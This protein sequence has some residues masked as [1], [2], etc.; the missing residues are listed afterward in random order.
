MGEKIFGLVS[1]AKMRGDRQ[2]ATIDSK[3]RQMEEAKSLCEQ[4]SRRFETALADEQWDAINATGPMSSS[5]SNANA[6]DAVLAEFVAFMDRYLERPHPLLQRIHSHQSV[7]D[8]VEQA[9][10]ALDNVFADKEQPTSQNGTP[11]WQLEVDCA[12]ELQ[13]QQ[14]K[15]CLDQARLTMSDRDMIDRILQRFKQ[16]TRRKRSIRMTERDLKELEWKEAIYFKLFRLNK[17]LPIDVPEWFIAPNEVTLDMSS[18]SDLGSCGEIYSGMWRHG[19]KVSVRRL[20]E[21]NVNIKAMMN[22]TDLWSRLNHPHIMKLFGACHQGRP[23]FVCED[24][25]RGH[26]GDYLSKPEN[27]K[28]TWRMLY[29]ASLGLYYLHSHRIAH[30]DLRCRNVRIGVDGKAKLSNFSYSVKLN[31]VSTDTVISVTDSIRW[32]A[33]ECFN[34]S[35]S[36]SFASDIYSFGMCIIEATTGKPPWELS[37]DEMVV[38]HFVSSNQLPVQPSQLDDASWQLVQRMCAHEPTARPSIVSVVDE[39]KRLMQKE[40]AAA[41]LTESKK[42][43]FCT[44]CGNAMLGTA[45]FCNKCGKRVGDHPARVVSCV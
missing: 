14:L 3:C 18:S 44:S 8:A 39:L 11:L 2:V 32:K 19:T 30:G 1:F 35:T 34:A 16:E 31:E 26:L 4:V 27:Q 25:V 28:K 6:L 37:E 12:R 36:F 13:Q 20:R 22:E 7:V 43:K 21:K 15:Q 17:S 38:K 29:E 5:S 23:F 42:S 45:N 40:A 9:H 24:A 41:K 10:R 33:P